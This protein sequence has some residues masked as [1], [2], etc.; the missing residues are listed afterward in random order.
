[1]GD[2]CRSCAQ[3]RAG[4]GSW[5]SPLLRR[6]RRARSEL[7]ST[8]TDESTN[9]RTDVSGVRSL[10]AGKRPLLPVGKT[11]LVDEDV[12]E[13]DHV[14]LFG[15]H[16]RVLAGSAAAV[17][18]DRRFLVEPLLVESFDAGVD[19]GLPNGKASRSGDV[20]LRVDGGA[21]GVQEES[22]RLVEAL[23]VRRRD[24]D[25]GLVRVR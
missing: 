7:G 3:R 11:V 15:E 5:G 24:L 16:V 22:L 12:V 21:P 6:P 19:V 8:A 20:P 18:D 14:E 23:D 13:T 17:D 9:P 4:P 25:R 2:S 1:P 10:R